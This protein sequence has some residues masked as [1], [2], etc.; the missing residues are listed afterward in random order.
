M[1]PSSGSLGVTSPIPFEP[2]R[3][4]VLSTTL[5]LV[6]QAAGDGSYLQA[7][8]LGIV[9][10]V[11]EML[12]ISSSGHLILLPRFFGWEDQGLAFDA[13]MHVGTLLAV[14]L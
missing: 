5:P 8:V 2:A 4:F 12:P 7:V 1:S 3:S 14:L 6:A 10:G 11:T 13:A 9:Q